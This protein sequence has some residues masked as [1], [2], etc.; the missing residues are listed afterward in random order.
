MSGDSYDTVLTEVDTQ[1]RDAYCVLNYTSATDNGYLRCG[2]YLSQAREWGAEMP[3]AIPKDADIINAVLICTV[4]DNS[5]WGVT[6]TMSVRAFAVDNASAFVHGASEWIHEHHTRG[7]DSTYWIS[8]DG[9]AGDRVERS[10]DASALVQAV[11]NRSGWSSGNYIGFC[12]VA[13]TYVD[14]NYMGF[15]DYTSGSG[16]M[17]LRVVYH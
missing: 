6:D 11:V 2:S 17:K 13:K 4:N 9:W 3:L 8:P 15:K 12:G 7:T 1:L 5:G 14:P 10:F 16:R